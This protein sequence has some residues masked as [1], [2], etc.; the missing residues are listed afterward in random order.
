[1]QGKASSPQVIVR[2]GKPV[3]V[4]LDLVEYRELLE[5]AEDAADLEA[6]EELRSEPM[7]F[8]SLQE[9]LDEYSPDA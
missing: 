5:R 3:A 4:I 1:M 9:F 8:R 2:D 6:L 7:E